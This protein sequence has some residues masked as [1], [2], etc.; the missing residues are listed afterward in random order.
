MDD[1]STLERAFGHITAAQE[2]S[3]GLIR[4]SVPDREVDAAISR[5][6]A[7]LGQLLAEEVAA[8]PWTRWKAASCELINWWAA[9]LMTALYIRP[10]RICPQNVHTSPRHIET[11]TIC[12]LCGAL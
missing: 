10:F 9:R 1:R 7:M 4:L 12:P 5:T 2:T 11:V 6:K 3:Q 8:T